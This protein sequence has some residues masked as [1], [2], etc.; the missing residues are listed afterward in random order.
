VGAINAGCWISV[1]ARRFPP[2]WSVEELNDACFIVRDSSG[3]PH[4]GQAT[5]QGRGAADCGEVAVL[6]IRENMQAQ[7]KHIPHQSDG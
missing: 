4:G 5:Q 3:Q 2:L 6:S 1:T 7:H